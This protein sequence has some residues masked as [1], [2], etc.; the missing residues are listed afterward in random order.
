MLV[1]SDGEDQGSHASLADVE[2]RLEASDVSLYMIGEGRGVKLEALQKIMTRL[3]S[4]TGGRSIVTEKVDDLRSAF[5][6]ILDEL[7]HQYLLG[8]TSTNTS[9]DGALRHLK[10]EVDGRHQVRAR[11]AYRA[12]ERKQ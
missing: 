9:H 2:R 11:E 6:E 12:P 10:V 4:K 5:T 3:A 8:Y 1:F 7:S